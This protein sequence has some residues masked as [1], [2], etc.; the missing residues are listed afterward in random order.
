MAAEETIIDYLKERMDRIEDKSD[1]ML[2]AQAD[3][4]QEFGRLKGLPA[5]IEKTETRIGAI[6][7]I[8][9]KREGAR[10]TLAVILGAIGSIIFELFRR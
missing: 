4:K 10:A 3:L 6:E 5:R 9:L 2:E 7:K 8:E 1:K